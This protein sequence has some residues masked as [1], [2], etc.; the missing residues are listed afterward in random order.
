MFIMYVKWLQ[1]ATTTIVNRKAWNMKEKQKMW[2][3]ENCARSRIKDK[4]E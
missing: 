1:D 2:T 4:K 3:T